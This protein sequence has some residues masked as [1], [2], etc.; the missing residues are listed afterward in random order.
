MIKE[1]TTNKS[2][3]KELRLGDGGQINLAG[4]LN[5]AYIASRINDNQCSDILNCNFDNRGEIRKRK[6]KRGNIWNL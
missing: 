1:N 6:G 5:L 2:T 3:V 4:G